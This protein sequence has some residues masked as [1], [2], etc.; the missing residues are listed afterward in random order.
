MTGKNFFGQSP[1]FKRVFSP[2]FA[3]FLVLGALAFMACP[4]EEDSGGGGPGLD[5]RLRGTWDFDDPGT[6][7]GGERYIIGNDN[8]LS[9]SSLFGTGAAATPTEHWAGKIVHAESYTNTAGVIIIEYTQEKKQVWSSWIEVPIGSNN[10]VSAPL[11]PQPAG[12]FYGIY[13]SHIKTRDDGK[14]EVKFS[15]TSDQAN[16]YG[17]TE[18]ET[19]EDAIKKFTV[20]NMNQLMDI[21][22]GEP[23]YKVN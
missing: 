10:W 20:E 21:D 18:V 9:Y 8:S 22:A 11:D 3:L 2:L 12:N 14:L 7:Y 15:N 19:L 5:S 23:V 13:Y 6:G 1:L 16:N 4:M 17:P